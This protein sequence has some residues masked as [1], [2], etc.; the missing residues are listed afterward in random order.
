MREL[1]LQVLIPDLV[2]LEHRQ[3]GMSGNVG[4]RL[5]VV[6]STDHVLPG[7]GRYNWRGCRGDG[8]T[9]LFGQE[10]FVQRAGVLSMG[11][12]ARQW[13]CPVAATRVLQTRSKFRVVGYWDLLA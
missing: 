6:Q 9:G 10:L 8:L 2:N 11:R 1:L 3:T 5:S 7:G 13:R 4:R 12:S